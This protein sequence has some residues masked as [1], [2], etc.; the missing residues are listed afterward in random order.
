MEWRD[1]LQR[2]EAIV[3][4]DLKV[5]R[6]WWIAVLIIAATESVATT[7]VA[8]NIRRMNDL[9]NIPFTWYDSNLRSLYAVAAFLASMILG[10]AF[11][12]VHGGKVRRVNRSSRF[13]NSHGRSASCR[14]S[15]WA[16]GFSR[17]CSG[18]TRHGRTSTS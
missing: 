1:R 13:N 3:E 8:S 16:P 15:I 7:S 11:S 4:K 10:L 6:W 5:T 12:Y 18:S 2:I 9:Y 14:P 17:T